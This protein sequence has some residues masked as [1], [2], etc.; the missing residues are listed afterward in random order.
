MGPDLRTQRT[1]IERDLEPALAVELDR[2]MLLMAGQWR[3]RM[4]TARPRGCRRL[5]EVLVELAAHFA[6]NGASSLSGM[7][8]VRSRAIGALD[9]VP[10]SDLRRQEL[11]A[12]V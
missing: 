12:D 8:A 10:L 7:A 9:A 6:L 11:L 3:A 5:D 1:P 4:S 2:L